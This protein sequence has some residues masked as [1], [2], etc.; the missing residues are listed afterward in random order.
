M[1]FNRILISM[2][3]ALPLIACSDQPGKESNSPP[4]ADTTAPSL[5]PATGSGTASGGTTGSGGTAGGSPTTPDPL[6]PPIATG[7]SSFTLSGPV[8]GSQKNDTYLF[9]IC[10]GN[11]C[12]RWQSTVENGVFEYTFEL[13]Q[14]PLD[15]SVLIEGNKLDASARTNTNP[16]INNKANSYFKTELDSLANLQKWDGNKDGVLN[17]KEVAK[18]SFD[19]VTMAYQTVASYLLANQLKHHAEKPYDEKHQAIRNYLLENSLNTLVIPTEEQLQ[20]FKDHVDGLKLGP[21]NKFHGEYTMPLTTEQWAALGGKAETAIEQQVIRL[22]TA[23][24]KTLFEP[25]YNRE[26]TNKQ[27]RLTVQQS[28]LIKGE[29]VYN[30]QL[31]LELSA[32]YNLLAVQPP[33]ELTLDY[34][35]SRQVTDQIKALNPGD[36]EATHF[37]GTYNVPLNAAHLNQLGLYDVPSG[38]NVSLVVNAS[39]MRDVYKTSQLDIQQ[40]KTGFYRFVLSPI[41]WPTADKN[42]HSIGINVLQNLSANPS[43][44]LWR[45]YRDSIVTE[46]TPVKVYTELEHDFNADLQQEYRFL[47]KVNELVMANHKHP[48]KPSILGLA[49]EKYLRFSGRFPP[50]LQSASLQIIL[51]SRP[52][53]KPGEHYDNGRYPERHNPV[54]L[55][56]NDGERKTTLDLKGQNGFVVKIALRDIDN[57][58]TLCRPGRPYEGQYKYEYTADEMQDQLTVHIVDEKTGTELRSVLGSFCELAQLDKK[59][60][61]GNDILEISE[62]ERLNVGYVSTAQSVLLMK[63]SLSKYGTNN[64]LHPWRHE[65][66]VAMYRDM[67]RKQVE[68][69][70]AVVA[71]QAKGTLLGNK[72]NLVERATFYEDLLALAGMN[73]YGQHGRLSTNNLLPSLEAIQNNLNAKVSIGAILLSKLDVNISHIIQEITSLLSTST[74]DSYYFKNV[75]PGSWVTVYPVSSLDP[76]CQVKYNEN[77]LFGIGIAGKGKDSQGDWMTVRWD[78]QIGATNYIIG[79]QTT[80]FSDINSAANKITTQ[81]LYATLPALEAKGTYYI[82][83]QSDVGEVS[84]TLEYRPHRTFL[85]DSRVTQGIVGDDSTRGRDSDPSC[86]PLSG[87]AKNSNSDG[88]LGARYI[89][90]DA[91]GLPL[92]RQDLTYKQQSFQC[93]LDAQSGL[94]WETKRAR[95]ENQPYSI[96]DD[97]NMYAMAVPETAG[98]FTASCVLPEL[99][100]SSSDPAQ[101]N[102]ANQVKWVNQAK[103]CGLNNWRVPTMHELYTLLDFGKNHHMYMDTRY[104]PLTRLPTTSTLGTVWNIIRQGYTHGFWST[105]QSLDQKKNGVFIPIWGELQQRDIHE[106]H[107]LMLVSDGFKTEQQ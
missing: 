16:E 13:S 69:L 93:V 95:K 4:A 56:A 50:E 54:P 30:Q 29:L 5:P 77:Q 18:L 87:K 83:I 33:I 6:T 51:G 84:E 35:E 3:V 14:W 81:K 89:K 73:I 40:K 21:N 72:I 27:F 106:P 25:D 34:W 26:A 55:L 20:K 107:L 28:A 49:P 36:G 86:D 76:I 62:L 79:W 67:P 7:P 39:T 66:L 47:H 91:K 104:F 17:E 71:L 52:T 85:A 78:R 59:V 8:V 11:V 88:F 38:K 74:V 24:M 90:L 1:L 10:S 82:R 102:V 53:P 101:C 98:E 23:Q 68:L 92:R 37:E 31:V 9:K 75:R 42:L 22:N 32:L 64:Y 105:H 44:A 61:N 41:L 2:A 45:H 65:Q 97:D 70:A 19:S 100:I 96:H 15:K 80:P 43:R 57:H 48:L 46:A 103:L 99:N 94:V 12:D 63:M 58:F 60:G